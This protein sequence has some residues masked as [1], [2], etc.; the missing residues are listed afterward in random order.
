MAFFV[1]DLEDY[2]DN[3]GLYYDFNEITPGSLCKTTE[4]LV[5]YIKNINKRFDKEQVIN[6]KKKFMG[7][8]DG[9]S[10]ERIVSFIEN[11]AV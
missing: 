6:F 5:D 9:H 10:T 8:C 11:D 4:E 2:I 1:Y 3:R 7:S